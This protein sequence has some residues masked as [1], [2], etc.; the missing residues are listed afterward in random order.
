M[1]ITVCAEVRRN[2]IPRVRPRAESAWYALVYTPTED[3]TPPE[4][5]AIKYAPSWAEA[6]Q[7]AQVLRAELERELTD[8]MHESLAT[9]RTER[10]AQLAAEQQPV[11]STVCVW[12]HNLGHVINECPSWRATVEATR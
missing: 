5:S 6:M 2:R 7:A 11:P 10:A 8:E 12:C 1:T 3:D 4:R 9:R